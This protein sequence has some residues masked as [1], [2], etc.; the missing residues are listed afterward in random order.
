[1][2]KIDL[3]PFT[4][5]FNCL[6]F[7]RPSLKM[8]G[9]K[10]VSLFYFFCL[11]SVNVCDA[12]Q[13]LESFLQFKKREKHPLVFH[14]LKIVQTVPNRAKCLMYK[15][16]NINVTEWG[17]NTIKAKKECQS[18]LWNMVSWVMEYNC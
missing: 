5:S 17:K 7:L 16:L 9:W 2:D 11:S 6:H 10:Q 14:V 12:L 4:F 15:K 1:M 13:D 18:L 3:A 8:T